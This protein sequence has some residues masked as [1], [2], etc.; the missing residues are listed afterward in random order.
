MEEKRQVLIVEDN[1]RLNDYLCRNLRKNGF[2]ALSALDGKGAYEELKKSLVDLVI[3]DINL[4]EVNGLDILQVIRR[5]D[6]SLPVLILSSINSVDS[7]VDG[8]KRGCDD[9]MTKPFYI[10]ELLGRINRMLER[11]DMLGRRKLPIG[12]TLD[13][14]PFHLDIS[15]LS[16][17]KEGRPIPIRKR[18]FELLLYFMRNANVLL[19][20]ERI[21]EHVWQ[22]ESRGGDSKENTLYVHIRQLRKLIEDDPSRPRYIVTVRNGGY[23]FQI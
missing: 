6:D 23:L 19:S 7:K 18:H 5:Q 9:Y 1:P 11:T 22:G 4:G 2:A 13:R 8:F 21:L 20:V 3:L 15:S 17:S 16:L 10:D 14:P 12:E